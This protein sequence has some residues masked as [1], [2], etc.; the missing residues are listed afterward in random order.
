ML[1]KVKS[2]ISTNFLGVHLFYLD[3]Y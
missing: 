3:T 2:V 1:L